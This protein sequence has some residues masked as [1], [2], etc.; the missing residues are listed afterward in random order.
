[1]ARLWLALVIVLPHAALANRA[2]ACTCAASRVLPAPGSV[3]IPTNARLWR[4]P[5]TSAPDQ[6]I[7][8]YELAPHTHYEIRDGNTSFTTGAGRDD[9]APVEPGLAMVSITLAGSDSTGRKQVSILH[10]ASMMDSDVAVVRL[11]FLDA[12]GEV[13]YY[14]TPD[15]LSV[16]EPDIALTAGPVRVTL[17]ALDLAGHASGQQTIETQAILDRSYQPSCRRPVDSAIG[18]LLFLLVP[19]AIVFGLV[20]LLVINARLSTR[21]APAPGPMAIPAVEALARTIR[22]RALVLLVAFAAVCTYTLTPADFLALAA[23]SSP[24]LVVIAY[25]ALAASRALRLHRYDGVTAE[26]RGA[27][28]EILVG[29]QRVTLRAPRWLVNRKRYH[30]VPKATL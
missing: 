20:V 1:M 5:A 6:P 23:V 11:T 2:P 15:A 26:A 10:V 25:I 27:H 17:T 21:A 13:T 28:V 9:S 7:A 12:L 8:S 3:D 16:C 29:K 19:I 24:L 14:T 22:L 30:G 18:M 4:L